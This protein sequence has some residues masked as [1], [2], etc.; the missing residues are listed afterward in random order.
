MT[1][2]KTTSRRA[3]QAAARNE[4]T[5][6]DPALSRLLAASI[7]VRARRLQSLPIGR[8]EAETVYI[9]RSGVLHVAARV[10]GGRREVLCLL[11]PGDIFRTASAPPLSDVSL[12]AASAAEVGRLRWN[13]VESLAHG[14]IEVARYLS[15]AEASL[16]ARQMLHAAAIGGLSGEARAASF[17]I[18]LGLRTGQRTAGGVAIDIAL[19]RSDIADYLALNADTLSRIMTRLRS[20]GILT[21]SGRRHAVIT[22]WPGLC[23]LSPI[24]ETQQKMEQPAA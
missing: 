8:G 16:H 3:A 5:Q 13:A 24:A 19:T 23:S 11:Y 18:E 12:I 6:M 17:L 7:T 9:I 14:D 22:D 4:T 10:P 15:R 21:Q 1:T 2:L 20:K